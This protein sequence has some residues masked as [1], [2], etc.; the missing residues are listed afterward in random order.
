MAVSLRGQRRNPVR[1]AA[2]DCFV[3]LLLAMTGVFG[4]FSPAMADEAPGDC[5][6][7]DFDA[8][9]PIAIAKITADKPRT[10]FLK[11]VS[12][13][14]ACPSDSEACRKKAYLIPGNLVLLDKTF[15]DKTGSAYACAVY[16][17]AE[18]KKVRWSNGWLPAASITKIQPDPAPTRADWLGDWTHSAGHIDIA[19]G[20]DGGLTIKGEG[21]YQAAQNVHTGVI[22]ATAKPADGLLQ[23]ADDGSVPFDK[24]KDGAECLV[25][26]QRVG[27]L[28]VVE[29]NNGC[30]GVMVTFTGFYRRK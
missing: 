9:H 7:V 11:N 19:S 17:S 14:A 10:H 8:A 13:N 25:R 20:K 16:E 24:A 18:D 2:L 4:A 23:F 12:D 5:F 1:A 15:S 6:G 30:G 28:L 3:A 26:M 21:F 29:D 27:A 22:D